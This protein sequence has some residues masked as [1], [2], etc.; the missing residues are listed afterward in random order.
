MFE[1]SWRSPKRVGHFG[2]PTALFGASAEFG[3]G[4]F[5][6]SHCG[7]PTA[8]WPWS[9]TAPNGAL[10]VSWNGRAFRSK[11]EALG[12]L[13]LFLSGEFVARR[14][15]GESQ[16]RLGIG[17]GSLNLDGPASFELCKAAARRRAWVRFLDSQRVDDMA[18]TRAAAAEKLVVLKVRLPAA[19]V[20]WA[21]KA[22]RE[23][24]LGVADF[25]RATV[26][27][28]VPAE[29]RSAL[30]ARLADGGKVERGLA[31]ASKATRRAVCLGG[32]KGRQ[33]ERAVAGILRS[34]QWVADRIVAEFLKTEAGGKVEASVA[35]DLEAGRPA[36][37]PRGGWAAFGRFM[38]GREVRAGRGDDVEA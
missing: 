27:R 20:A 13:A 9:I 21:E 17:R 35:A 11:A 7:H 23:A 4:A 1:I 16:V 24:G 32:V 8:L 12:G 29:N 31:R 10:L 3:A 30:T 38:G 28:A 15:Y 19:V 26:C 33:V 14:V 18:G 5:V 6:V 2:K 25:V 34:R 36:K 37:M 22:G